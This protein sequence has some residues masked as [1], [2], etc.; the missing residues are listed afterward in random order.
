LATQTTVAGG[1]HRRGHFQ[2]TLQS[3]KEVS[4]E[5]ESGVKEMKKK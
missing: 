2:K 5:E 4:F 3:R 1:G